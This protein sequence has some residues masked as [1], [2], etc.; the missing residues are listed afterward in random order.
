MKKILIYT[1]VAF[2][3]FSCTKDAELHYLKEKYAS[4]YA[5]EI[6]VSSTGW[7]NLKFSAE[8]F[9]DGYEEII[10]HGFILGSIPIYSGIAIT[11]KEYLLKYGT[12]ISLGKL[13]EN[14]GQFTYDAIVVSGHKYWVMA[15]IR[16]NRYL[17]YSNVATLTLY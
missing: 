4:I 12:K 11:E 15:Y 1:S 6:T 8:I 10:D 17:I 9:N 13:D 2:L 5:V 7:N 3:M 16:T 14:P